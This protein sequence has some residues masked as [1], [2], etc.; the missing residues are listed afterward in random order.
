MS[1]ENGEVV[2]SPEKRGVLPSENDKI[3]ESVEFGSI[4][5]ALDRKLFTHTA[6]LEWLTTVPLTE[7]TQI[8]YK[9]VCMKIPPIEQYLADS[10][11]FLVK[12]PEY[13]SLAVNYDFNPEAADRKDSKDHNPIVAHLCEALMRLN[14]DADLRKLS[15]LILSG[16][17]AASFIRSKLTTCYKA[18]CFPHL[19]RISANEI[20]VSLVQA[21]WPTKFRYNENLANLILQRVAKLQEQA[22]VYYAEVAFQAYNKVAVKLNKDKLLTRLTRDELITFNTFFPGIVD[23]RILG[24]SPLAYKIALL[25]NDVAG[26]VLGFPIQNMIPGETQIHQ[27]VTFLTEK[28]ADDYAAFIRDYVVKTYIPVLPFPEEAPPI[29]PNDTDVMFENIDNY[30]PFDIIACQIGPHIHRFTRGEVDQLLETKRNHWNKEWLPPTVLATLSARQKAAKELGLP[31]ARPLR[32]MLDRVEKGT[33]FEADSGPKSPERS[34]SEEAPFEATPTGL[35]RALLGEWSPGLPEEMV[36]SGPDDSNEPSGPFGPLSMPSMMV[37]LPP[38]PA[39]SVS[40]PRFVFGSRARRFPPMRSAPFRSSVPSTPPIM[41]LDASS[42]AQ[43]EEGLI[44]DPILFDSPEE[45]DV[46][47]ISGGSLVPYDEDLQVECPTEP[48][49]IAEFEGDGV[50]PLD[51][52]EDED[53]IDLLEA[54][55]DADEPIGPATP[56]HL[57]PTSGPHGPGDLE[58]IPDFQTFAHEL[59]IWAQSANPNGTQRR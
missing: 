31:P 20:N 47:M 49:E 2:T 51:G 8:A 40:A 24:Y 21:D 53:D 25:G 15:A 55:E 7:E 18:R 37:P 11:H 39:P 41:L 10:W 12:K 16:D 28:G 48:G 19:R 23:T 33:L 58:D 36:V 14:G 57:P 30:A 5:L 43:N 54:M 26:Y 42:S 29:F 4:Y 52:P 50:I 34:P 44:G 17:G 45:Y 32:E 6:L 46:E 56:P 9:A 38:D 59:G 22:P 1:T 13:T 27:A 35:L 3:R